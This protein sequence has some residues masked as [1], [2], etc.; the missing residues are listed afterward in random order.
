MVD[1]IELIAET[2]YNEI[3]EE[4]WADLHPQGIERALYREAAEKVIAKFEQMRGI[5]Q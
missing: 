2:F 1:E 3:F 5:T 4:R